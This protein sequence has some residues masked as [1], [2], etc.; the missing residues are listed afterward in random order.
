MTM[1]DWRIRNARIVDGSG[2][3]WFRGDVGIQ[4]GRIVAVGNLGSARA[5]CEL[6]AAD[7]CLAPGFI[8][9]HTHS[10]FS[11]PRFPRAESRIS[12]GVTTEVGGNCGF[13]PF[14]VEPSR[15]DLLRDSSSFIA[16]NLAWD[17]RSAADFFRHLEGKPLSLNF[18]PLVAHGAV[19]VAVMGF[20]RRPPTADELG[21]MEAL[22][23]EAMEAGAAGISSGLAY[24]PGVFSEADELIALCRVVARYGGIYATHMR[25]QEAGL[26]DS[27]EESLRVGREAGVPVQI[28]HHKAMGEAYWGR[29]KDS[30]AR[31]D[32]ARRDGQDVTLDVYPYTA[33]STT[34]TRFLPAWTLEGGVAALLDRLGAADVRAKIL[35][36]ASADGAVKWENV[37]IAA[38]R[39]PAHARYEGMT[40]EGLGKD[41]GK[42]PLAAAVEL[43]LA[44]GAPFPIIRFVMS[45]EDV[46]TVLRHPAVMIGSDGYAI[47]PALGSKPHPR[48][49]GTFT[50]VLGE[51]VREKRVLTLEDAIRKMTSF[52]AARFG[53]SDRG[54]IRPGHMADLTLF[55]AATFEAPHQYSEGIAWVMVGGQIVWQDGRDTGAVAG[56]VLRIGKS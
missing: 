56:R 35:A 26:L 17:W 54:M 44:D 49:Y 27:V 31:V 39:K 30:L 11:L 45:E 41:V 37:R 18:I 48:S 33:V 42:P 47:A 28:S 46:R 29:V 4:A 40:L 25:D 23:A 34:V 32:E 9:A 16:T 12:Q 21:R 38:L 1:L 36:E 8:D 24:A 22:V 51:Y 13:S 50:R 6:D 3:P 19:R 15:L 52:P 2:N 7:R 10:D 43:I 5:V 53:L 20:D 55:D 14:P